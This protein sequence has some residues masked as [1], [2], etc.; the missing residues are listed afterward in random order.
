MRANDPFSSPVLKLPR[1]I[2]ISR[3]VM[4]FKTSISTHDVR[5]YSAKSTKH[6]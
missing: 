5:T 3:V 1:D 6:K 4:E 2:S